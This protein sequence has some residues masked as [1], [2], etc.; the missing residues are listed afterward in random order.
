[1]AE[2]T[3]KAYAPHWYLDQHRGYITIQTEGGPMF[4]L[5]GFQG[6]EEFMLVVDLLRNEQP[7]RWDDVNRRLRTTLEP[8]GEAEV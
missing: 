8:V 6:P 3:V 5:E 7:V 2:F 1:M 4:G